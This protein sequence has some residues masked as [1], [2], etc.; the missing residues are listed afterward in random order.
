MTAP[1]FASAF[2]ASWLESRPLSATGY[3]Y[4]SCRRRVMRTAFRCRVGRGGG[5]EGWSEHFLVDVVVV[6]VLLLLS[7]VEPFHPL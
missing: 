1:S 3:A 5:E 2:R 4:P 6:V 7:G